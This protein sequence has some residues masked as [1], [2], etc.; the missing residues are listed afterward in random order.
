MNLPIPH[1]PLVGYIDPGSGMM[2]F[3]LV[4]AGCLSVLA[5]FRKSILRVLG[6]LK[7]SGSSS[8]SNP[9][10]APSTN[11]AADLPPGNIVTFPEQPAEGETDTARAA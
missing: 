5:Y 6:L 2:L 1:L 3:Q 11:P 8:K 10:S 7:G 9:F 4:L